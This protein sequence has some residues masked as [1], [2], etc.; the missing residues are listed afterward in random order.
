M[1]T[2]GSTLLSLGTNLNTIDD[3]GNLLGR[4]FRTSATAIMLPKVSFH[5][6]RT[7]SEEETGVAEALFRKHGTLFLKGAFDRSLIEQVAEA[8]ARKYQSFC[9]KELRKRDAMVGE[10]R[11]LSLIHI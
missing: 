2:A 7:P 6:P 9:R 3:R 4:F 8:C 5:S 10:R 1:V 11:Y